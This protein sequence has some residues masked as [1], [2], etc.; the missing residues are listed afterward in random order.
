MTLKVG[1]VYRGT[2]IYVPAWLGITKIVVS[3]GGQATVYYRHLLWKSMPR[4]LWWW[5][6]GSEVKPEGFVSKIRTAKDLEGERAE[7]RKSVREIEV[8]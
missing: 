3:D 2:W 1:S 7:A 5:G 6:V 4:W 8:P